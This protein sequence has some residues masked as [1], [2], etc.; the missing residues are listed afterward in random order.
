[1]DSATKQ[2]VRQFIDT[3]RYEEAV[4]L[5]ELE[6]SD[7]EAKWML[8]EIQLQ[9]KEIFAVAARQGVEDDFFV[10]SCAALGVI[11]GFLVI[12]G[13]MAA[14]SGSNY[15]DADAPLGT[16]RILF[17]GYGILFWITAYGVSNYKIWG[18]GLAVLLIGLT[19]LG[20]LCQANCY[21][22]ICTLPIGGY[23]LMQFANNRQ[24]FQEW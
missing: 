22:L 7:P 15:V 9:K 11:A 14:S 2:R 1:M 24:A 21:A 23:Y 12:C 8:Q 18:A 16:L 17:I 4:M 6:G 19:I 13:G 3:G 10:K 20:N 5:L